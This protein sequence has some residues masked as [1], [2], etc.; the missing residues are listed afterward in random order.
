MY[1]EKKVIIKL[2]F[3]VSLTLTNQ[4]SCTIKPAS[5]YTPLQVAAKFFAV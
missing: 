3:Y 5:P 2:I 1:S 4:S